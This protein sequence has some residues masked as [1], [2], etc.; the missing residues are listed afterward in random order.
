VLAIYPKFSVIESASPPVSPSV[1]A[2]ILINQKIKV[3][4]GTLLKSSVLRKS[5]SKCIRDFRG[6]SP[7]CYSIQMVE[8][9][10]A[11]FFAVFDSFLLSESVR[12]FMIQLFWGEQPP[13]MPFGRGGR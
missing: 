5:R 1:V 3:T 4:C 6:E 12:W 7:A 9:Q 8:R 11:L 2:Q 10:I 13:F